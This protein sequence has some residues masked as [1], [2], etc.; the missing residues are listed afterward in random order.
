MTRKPLLQKKRKKGEGKRKRAVTSSPTR[1]I[2]LLRRVTGRGK[3]GG[4]GGRPGPGGKEE[5]K[6]G[7][8]TALDLR[9]PNPY[10]S[11]A[12]VAFLGGGGKRNNRIMRERN[13]GGEKKKKKKKEKPEVKSG[14]YT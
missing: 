12:C 6:R 10:F 13:R 5:E 9:F 2:H 14:L 4:A 11:L 1:M 3:S 7:V 8:A